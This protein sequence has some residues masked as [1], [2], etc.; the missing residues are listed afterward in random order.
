MSGLWQ[1][2][3]TAWLSRTD[4][5]A[6]L[7]FWLGGRGAGTLVQ[8]TDIDEHEMRRIRAAQVDSVTR[9]TPVTMSINVANASLI[10]FTFWGSEARP[11][12]LAWMAMIVFAAAMAVRSWLQT[13]HEPRME[14]SA[15]AIRRMTLH[16]LLLGLIW[17][18]MP[19]MVFITAEPGDQ[20]IV[21]C[22]AAGMISGG[23]FTLST[24]PRAGLAYTWAL[25]AGSALSLALSDGTAYRITAVF[26][27]LYAGFMSRNLISHGEMFFD[28]LRAK[29]ELERQTE[30]I[31]LLLKDFQANASD[32]L[33]QTD[34]QGRLVHVPERFVEVA[35]LPPALMTGALL[36]DVIGML[37]S[38]DGRCAMGVAAKMAQREP[39][40]D[41]VVHVVIG[42]G[43]RLWSLT[44][45][46]MFDSNGEFTGY[47]GVGRDVT[48]RW[49]AEQAEAE[50]R[51][52][53]SFLAMMS[54]EIRT[55][56]N[57]VLGLANSLLETKLDPEQQQAVTTIRDSGDD[58]L[59]ILNDILDLSKLES[60]RLEF[61]QADFSPATLVESVR[62]IIEPE[63]RGKGI[64]LKIDIDPRL[65][66][67]LSGDAARIRQVLL[68]L[69]SNAVKFTE[70]GSIAIVLTCVKRNDSH[71]TVEW[72][73][74]DTGIGISPDRVGSL[75][76]D[77]AQADVSINR[78]FGG[79]GLGLAISRRIVE[80]MGGDI[81]VT[82]REGAGS[83]FRFSLDLPWSNAWI[84][85]HRLD[86]LG[87]DDLRTRIVMLGRP[88]RVLI[89]E[90]DA[91]NQMVVRKMLQE[92][93][94]EITIV[95]DG[96]DAVQAAGEGEFDVVLMD[97]RMPNMDGLAATSAIRNKGGALAKLPIIALTANAFPDD[98]KVCREAGMNDFLAKPLRKPALVAAVLRALRGAPTPA[99]VVAPPMQIDLD[100]LAELTEEIGRDQ[101]NE[102]VTLFFAE[103]ERRIALFRRCVDHL[104]REAV[105]VEAHSM[106]GGALTLGFHAIAEIARTI[107]RESGSLS[108]EALDSL[109]GQL[110]KTL[111]ELRRQC[112]GG[113]KLAS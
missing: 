16:A 102:M 93:A 40:N 18:A 50:N 44:A 72:Q 48:E 56:M 105:E 67:S 98:V 58:L 21:A 47:R 54:H 57:G 109:V 95:S 87:S 100:T 78:R 106:K 23:A 83:T 26:L 112:E 108:A 38:E 88:L 76:T 84:A 34:A 12:L 42:G 41:L 104:D 6:L 2:M 111:A 113:L 7:D 17:G 53:S 36:S 37:C 11:Q 77:F 73:V 75:F 14:A 15:H 29:F 79:T 97:V 89:A 62:A 4:G 46:P 22:V 101:V 85:D 60:G 25:A 70:H 33:W 59:R 1:S 28:N 61:E 24:V 82:S 5:A 35:K 86:R 13:R 107:E 32:W 80:Q 66:P 45:K 19:V 90:D 91:T 55:P 49:R 94:A 51:A 9:L 52:K 63:V 27:L 81:A 20:L 10:L 3:T 103:T 43:V 30:I 64:E 110:A 68:N 39:M 69:A 92:F 65:P 8:Q 31:S 96:A 99:K 74:T 71:A